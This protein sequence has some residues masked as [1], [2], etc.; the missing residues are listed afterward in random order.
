MVQSSD[1]ELAQKRI[2]I[3]LQRRNAFIL[4][5]FMFIVSLVLS[6]AASTYTFNCGIPLALITGFFAAARGYQWYFNTPQQDDPQRLIEQEMAWLFGDN[7]KATT[8][9]Y[10]QSLA[11]NRIQNRR[12]NRWIFVVHVII[13]VPSVLYLVIIAQSG[14]QYGEPSVA[15]LYLVP[16][17]WG[18]V[19]IAH[20][21]HTFPLPSLLERRERKAGAALRREVEAMKLS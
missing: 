21:L 13:F 8:G 20:L 1:Y 9:P 5:L 14:V 12:K 6:F 3:R 4:W 18:A 10:E 7:W 17:I 15:A 2:Q 19:F 11:E 16:V